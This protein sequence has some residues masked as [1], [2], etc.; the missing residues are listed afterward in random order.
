[1]WSFLRTD[2]PVPN[3][4]SNVQWVVVNRWT[5]PDHHA[6]SKVFNYSTYDRAQLFTNHSA[7]QFIKVFAV[8]AIAAIY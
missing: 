3:N 1:M 4:V 7:W 6:N 5:D 8:D 2:P